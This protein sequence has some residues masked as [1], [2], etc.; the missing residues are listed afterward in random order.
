M[1]LKRRTRNK[2]L[3]NNSQRT[4]Y[5]PCSVDNRRSRGRSNLVPFRSELKRYTAVARW[6]RK[7]RECHTP[8]PFPYLH[9]LRLIA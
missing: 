8:V 5:Y 3:Y 2:V 9:S 1:T 6:S 4:N 7:I